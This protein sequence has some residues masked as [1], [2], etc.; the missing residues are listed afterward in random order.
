MVCT[1]GMQHTGLQLAL[2]NWSSFG[3]ETLRI[4]GLQWVCQ[5]VLVLHKEHGVLELWNGQQRRRP[6]PVTV[7]SARFVSECSKKL[8]LQI[9][10]AW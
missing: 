5:N 9:I 2:L 3:P 10:T 1:P 6:R 8:E 4:S 7:C